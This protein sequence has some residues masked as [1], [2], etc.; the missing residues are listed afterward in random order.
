LSR[1]LPHPFRTPE[2]RSRLLIA[3]I[4]SA[5]VALALAAAPS[6]AAA[7]CPCS[8]WSSSATP[9]TPSDSD[10]AAVEIGV[11]FQSDVAGYIQGIRFY[12]SA[13]NT[14]THV[15]SLWSSGGTK[16]AT[17]TFAKESASGWQQ[18]LFSTPVAIT[19]NTVY[20]ASYHTNV[21]HYAN[22]DHYFQSVGVD[23]APLHALRSGVSGANGVYRYGANSIFPNTAASQTNYWVDVVF[24]QA[25]D[26]PPTV[27]TQSPAANSTGVATT[28]D[29]KA[30]F[31]EDIQPLTLQF[32]LTDPGGSVVPATVSYD[33]VSRTARLV[34][35]SSL[36]GSTKYTATVSGAKDTAGN[37]MAPTSWSFT[38]AAP[39]RSCPCSLWPN[40]AVPGTVSTADNSAVEVG[41]KFRSD[42][43][44]YIT[45]LRFYKGAS[46]TGTHVGH[47]WSSTGTLL[48]Q[49]TFAGETASGWQQVT[50]PAP[51]PITK[52]TT[53]VASYHTDA[54]FYSSNNDYFTSAPTDSAPLH[55]LQDGADGGNGVYRYGGSAFPTLTYRGS[56]YWV[57]AVFDR[58]AQDTIAPTVTS[59][60]PDSGSTSAPATTN[61]TATFSEPVQA[62]TIKLTGPA[63]DVPGNTTYDGPSQT[64]TFAPNA[65]LVNSTPYTA[66]VSGAKDAAGN[67]MQPLTWSFTTAAAAPPPPDQG[68][69]GP[70]LVV[71]SSADPFTKY[72][73]EILRNEGLNEFS[74][75]DV[76][77][78]SASSLTGR[79]VVV[80]ANV[81]LS[82]SQV[83]ALTNFVNNGGSLIAMRP[84]SQL[85]G[86]LGITPATGTLSEG[87]LA[88]NTA[89]E[90]AAGITSQTMQFHGIADRY[91][92]SGASTVA[93]LYSNAATATTNPAVTVRSVG[94]NGGQAAAFTYD[95][96]RSVVLTRQGD[97]AWAGQERD[98]QS[99][100]RSDDLFFGGSVADWV[101]LSKVA[102]PEADEQQR[103]LANLTETMTRHTK[104][105]PRFWYF[106]KGLKAVFVGTGD[107]HGNGGTAGRFDQYVA[108]SPA[109]CS[110]ADWSCLRFTSYMYPSTPVSNAQAAGYD[111]QGF[112]LGLH[113]STGCADYTPSSLES[114][115]ATQLGD[116]TNK[117]A[118][119]PAPTT[120]RTHCIAWSDWAGEPV[121]E[122]NHN[123]RFDTNYYYWPGSWVNDRPGLFTGSGMPMRFAQ[124]DGT[125][126]DVYQAATEMTAESNQSYPATPAALLDGALGPNGYYGAFTANMHTDQAQTFEDDQLLAT[127]LSRQVP[128]VSS[129]Q[130]L[131]WLDGRNGS[132]FKNLA[133]SGNALS[134]SVDIGAGARNLTV[135]LPTA[136]AAG[137]LSSIKLG[138]NAVS[139]RTDT[140]KGLEY[141][142]F[143]A[144]VGT[145]TATYGTSSG[146]AG[147][148][149][150]LATQKD[151]G[152][153]TGTWSAAR[154]GTDDAKGRTSL[155]KPAGASVASLAVAT[156]KPA[157]KPSVDNVQAA[158]L[159]DGTTS[160][161][162]TTDQPAEI[163]VKY[164]LSST[165]L[166][167]VISEPA[168]TTDHELM[169]P[170]LLPETTYYFELT[171][172]N[173]AG[174]TT[175]SVRSFK[176]PR[177]GVAISRVAQW[178]MGSGSNV[179]QSVS[180]QGGRLQL[181][182]GA[183]SGS[184]VSGVQDVHQMVSWTSVTWDDDVPSGTGVTYSI[185]TGSTSRPDSTWSDWVK[186]PAN[187]AV[188]DLVPDS[189]YVQYRV[190]MT[191][192]S[193]STPVVRSLGVTSTGVPLTFDTET[194]R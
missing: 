155:V 178:R 24:T 84:T 93:T 141:A 41:V 168:M 153:A 157:S 39:P 172:T 7:A 36:A 190:D 166:D 60:S 122:G 73:A 23:N 109:G 132:S 64:A 22:D 138:G 55:A 54:G 71:T 96:A 56:N 91:T 35:S 108:N 113:T 25:A 59:K 1:A 162:F 136:S 5:I 184:Y 120:N 150:A 69:G 151:A 19:A 52:G 90:A 80:V 180:G 88:V 65:R 111:Q 173:S 63:G 98:G 148:L 67:T 194:K 185:R 174:I 103:L 149:S 135:M 62:S 95:L 50:L 188:T 158:A 169:V 8:I 53:Y 68:P 183:L 139:Y 37:T 186:V 27:T 163:G 171:A 87:Y 81:G 104:P 126:I 114:N 124:T 57:D 142:I 72:Y 89:Q 192:T 78:L 100:I 29:V 140:I 164:G 154:V 191:G 13:Q 9:Q 21:G 121:T 85:A 18:V 48:S 102:V 82:A 14:G 40:S 76:T 43:D 118:S 97:P 94:S 127:A 144:D 161:T 156:S 10:T 79:D 61:V 31:S 119:V 159:P 105:L 115:F 28:T 99:P 146:T 110:V 107:D 117:Y 193:K 17:A 187:G 123:I 177:H 131:T 45:G 74:T 4:V 147:T 33:S 66:T 170:R 101:N 143:T 70:I 129:R 11:K 106:P 2:R 51:V 20:V 16:L 133:W 152:A 44:G 38:T 15:G 6:R 130:M 181:D 116:W 47:L 175:S 42:D 86:L 165:S 83:T 30:T 145:Y 125:M 112:E 77:S 32:Q 179:N 128:I 46:N 12:K 75:T 160:V 26:P 3:G 167:G 49:A 92:L 58:T 34:P 137:L 182:S 134:F 176:T 189:R